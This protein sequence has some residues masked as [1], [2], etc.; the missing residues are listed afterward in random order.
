MK[1]L[2]LFFVLAICFN[3]QAQVAINTDGSDPDNSAMLDVKSTLKGLL[4]PRM[5]KTE[6]DAILNPAI[7]LLIYQTQPPAGLYSYG[8]PVSPSWKM[9]GSNAG[10]WNSAGSSIYYNE[11]NVGI[12]TSNPSALLEVNADALINGLTIGKGE[13]YVETNTAL[14]EGALHSNTTGFENTAIGYSA[15]YS[16]TTGFLNLGIGFESLYSN[17]D[18]VGNI[19]VGKEALHS[20]ISGCMNVGI[21]SFTG[22]F[23]NS[24]Q[25]TCI[26]FQ[27]GCFHT[28]EY[29]TFL[30]FNSNSDEDGYS[31]CMALGYCSTVKASNQVK[32]GNS[33]VSSIGGYADWTTFSDERYKLNVKE[34]VKGLEFILKL[35]PVTYQLDAHKL[36]SD[37]GENRMID[38]SGNITTEI[39]SIPDIE[40]RDQK[41]AIV[42]TGFIAQEVENAARE[43]GFDFSGVD[44]P[45]NEN[46]YYGLR[47]AGFVV[48][49]VKAVQ[50]QQSLIE[51]Q[52]KLI[53]E[54]QNAI[55]G[56]LLRIEELEGK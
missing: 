38:E 17:T 41:S 43:I 54:M 15:L 10:Q 20:N 44:A 14:G 4:I 53:V 39:P 13:G 9:V 31:N 34:N 26:G 21:G 35:R 6:R 56:L 42:N 29:S 8:G 50:E 46:G 24:Y 47:Y 1:T 18:G 23:V 33:S 12:G 5:S 30:G 37:L 45:G 27:A 7:G 2:F 55:A 40:S 51:T 48:P 3:I 32:V 25:N 52:H 22:K 16:N 28:F 49:L 36:A 19:A 11:G